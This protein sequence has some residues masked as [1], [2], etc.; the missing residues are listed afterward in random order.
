MEDHSG[1]K[2]KREGKE[3]STR[4][5]NEKVVAYKCKR[6]KRGQAVPDEGGRKWREMVIDIEGK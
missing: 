6:C 1:I 5:R 2:R 3:G 4:R